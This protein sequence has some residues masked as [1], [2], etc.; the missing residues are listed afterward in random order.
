MHY[1]GKE[2]TVLGVARLES[3]PNAEYVVYR[4]EYTSD[5][6]GADTIWLRKKENFEEQI[7]ID[8]RKQ[9]RF[10]KM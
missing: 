9:E 5:D 1:K 10:R 2:Y 4:A 6:F 8:D 7:T 3:D